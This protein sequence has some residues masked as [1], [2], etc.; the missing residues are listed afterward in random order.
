MD[1]KLDTRK[2]AANPRAEGM[3]LTLNEPET[4]EGEQKKHHENP[5]KERPTIE[6]PMARIPETPERN[7]KG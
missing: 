4:L 7:K 2:I 1:M 6:K 3:H 5:P